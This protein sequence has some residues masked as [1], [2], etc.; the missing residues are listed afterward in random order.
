MRGLRPMPQGL[1]LMMARAY[2]DDET[3][4]LV[5]SLG[6]VS[7]VPAKRNRRTPTYDR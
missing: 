1:L 3:K 2:E 5:H 6:M 7:V 4:A